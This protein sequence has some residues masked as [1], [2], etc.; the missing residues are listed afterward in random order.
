MIRLKVINKR[1]VKVKEKTGEDS[2]FV[3]WHENSWIVN[4]IQGLR[5]GDLLEIGCQIAEVLF[6]GIGR[7]EEIRR[8][9]IWDNVK[10]VDNNEMKLLGRFF[11]KGSDIVVMLKLT[12]LVDVVPRRYMTTP[13]FYKIF[14]GS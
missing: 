5:I 13:G 9:G 3:F 14:G 10:I 11:E 7:Y 8:M 4:E 2:C 1:F 6:I 12:S